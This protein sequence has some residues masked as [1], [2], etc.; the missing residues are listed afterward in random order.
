MNLH[1]IIIISLSVIMCLDGWSQGDVAVNHYTGTALVNIPIGTVRDKDLATN[2]SLSYAASGIKVEQQAGLVGLGWNLSAGGTIS[3]DVRGLPDDVDMSGTRPRKGWLVDSIHTDVGNFS[4]STNQTDGNCDN[5]VTTWGKLNTLYG[6]YEHDT[7]PDIFY[8]N[9]SGYS[10]KFVFDNSGMIKTIPYVDFKID[11][12]QNASNLITS[13]TITTQ[14]GTE[15]VFSKHD[16][17]TVRAYISHPIGGVTGANP[18]YFLKDYLYYEYQDVDYYSTWY[19]EEINSAT[20]DAQIEFNYIFATDAVYDEPVEMMVADSSAN[21]TPAVELIY[22]KRYHLDRQV[23]S[24]ITTS[25]GNQIKFTYSVESSEG[26]LSRQLDDISV[27]HGESGT[28]SLI[29]EYDLTFQDLGFTFKDSIPYAR[30]F[31]KMVQEKSGTNKLPPYEFE[32]YGI[33]W[34]SGSTSAFPIEANSGARDY[35]G[36]YNGIAQL[37]KGPELYVY[38]GESNVDTYRLYDLPGHSGNEYTLK[39]SDRAPRES[40][41]K[42]ASLNRITWPSGGQTMLFHETHKY[43]DDAASTNQFGGGIRL[44]MQV[45]YDGVSHDNDITRTYEY[46]KT[47]GHSAGYLAYPAVFAVPSNFHEDF[48][49]GTIKYASLLPAN[50]EANYNKIVARTVKNMA[51]GHPTQGST[52]VYERVTEYLNGSGKKVYEFDVP[53]VFDSESEDSNAWEAAQTSLAMNK[54]KVVP[55]GGGDSICVSRGYFMKGAYVYPYAPNPFYDHKRGL[56]TKVSDYR[57]NGSDPVRTLEYVY[58]SITSGITTIQ[59]VNFEMEQYEP[60]GTTITI[61]IGGAEY[62]QF[63]EYT[64]RT[65]ENTVLTQVKESLY[66]DTDSSRAMVRTTDYEYNSSNHQ[67]LTK[68]STMNSDS[69]VHATHYLY[70]QD[71]D[72]TG[73][74]S[75]TDIIA[76]KNLIDNHRYNIPLEVR[77]TIDGDCAGASLTIFKVESAVARVDTVLEFRTNSPST[78][79]DTLTTEVTGGTRKLKHDTGYE[80]AVQILDYNS[81][82]LTSALYNPISRMTTGTIYGY[83]GQLPVVNIFNAEA[84]HVLYSGFENESEHDFELDGTGGLSTTA[85]AGKNAVDLGQGTSTELGGTV[86]KKDND[87]Y[88]A[89]YANTTATRTL[90]VNFNSTSVKS[91]SVPDTGGEWQYFKEL[92]SPSSWTFGTSFTVEITSQVSSTLIDEVVF[93]PSDADV[94]ITT[95]DPAFGV[96]SQTDVQGKTIYYEYD[97]HGRLERTRDLDGNIIQQRSYETMASSN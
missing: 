62:F 13:F 12:T 34:T 58:S 59:G 74:L 51:A 2:V 63:S 80:S 90:N 21:Y 50:S 52:V 97:V 85:Y 91:I 81:S 16:E 75:G 89:F 65:Q 86:T 22:F 55:P 19:L 7:E 70:P 20:T 17:I 87:Y 35:W 57:E 94:T 88:L 66:S 46:T 37:L 8:F 36:F 84:K 1:K 10:G 69:A 9:F 77:S 6:D 32:Y 25:F 27:Y 64:L 49:T 60:D 11:Y 56:L 76:V 45:A 72:T 83:E 61:T 43:R 71:I 41:T 92:I 73:T 40:Y 95:Y 14:D 18:Q 96:S 68:T 26:E 48:A 28:T 82:G 29:R 53:A 30:K 54:A 33:D 4:N 24:S 39:G 31:L 38:T 47:N 3:R 42:M 93:Y 78:S 79:F 67:F 15:Y 5:E 44:A 23:L